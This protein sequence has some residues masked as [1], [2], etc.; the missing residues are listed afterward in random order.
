MEYIDRAGREMAAWFTKQPQ[1]KTVLL[2]A[3]PSCP[4]HA[5]WARDFS[6][7][8]GPFGVIFRTERNDAVRAFVDALHQF[9]HWRQLERLREPRSSRRTRPDG[10]RMVRNVPSCPLQHWT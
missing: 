8:A 2:P 5:S 6:G 1:V 9:R 3:L 4:G 7:A 10:D